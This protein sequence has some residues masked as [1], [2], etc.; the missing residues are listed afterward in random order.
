M[1]TKVAT[2]FEVAIRL[3]KLMEDG[4]SKKVTERYAVDA[5]S[6]TEAESAVVENMAQVGDFE[7]KSETQAA[8]RE[9]FF[10]DNDEDDKW[11]K[12]KVQFV[13]L[14]EKTMVEKRST[15]VYLVQGASMRSALAN[16]KEVLSASMLDYS[17]IA[18]QQTKLIDVFGHEVKG[19]QK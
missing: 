5:M 6:F 9:V 10:S 1:K 8:Y 14:D 18:L 17:V 16:I 2:F 7:I 13:A 11:Y 4:S 15:V 3:E 12:A 19:Q